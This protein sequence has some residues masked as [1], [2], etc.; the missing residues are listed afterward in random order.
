M[1]AE[2]MARLYAI[3]GR[4][5]ASS[6]P[7]DLSNYQYDG[8]ADRALPQAVVM[9]ADTAQVA[10]VVRACNQFGVAFVAR[11]AGTGLSG[12]ALAE[13]GGVVISTARLCRILEIDALNRLAV[14]E[15]GV[16]NAQVSESVRHLGLYFVPDPSSQSVCTIGGNV[17]EN[18]GG[19]H[20]LA[21]GVTAHHVLGCEVVMPNGEI[22]WLGGKTVDTPGYDLLGVFVG[23]EG[24]LGITT[25]VVVKLV[26]LPEE[27]CTLVAAFPTI[28]QASQSVSDIIAAGIIP[29]ALEMMDQLS[30]QAV[31]AFV[32]AGFPTDAGAVVIVELEGL[33]EAVAE[34]AAAVQSICSHNDAR[35]IRRAKN[36]AERHLIWLGRK[37]TFGAMGQLGANYYV[38]DGVIPRTHLPAVVAEVEAIAQRYGL[39]IANVFHAGDG[40]LHPLIVFDDRVAGEYD[41]TVAAGA[42]ILRVCVRHG[43]SISGEHG[44]GIEKRDCMSLQYSPVDL[45]LMAK[46]KSA[47]N[48]R[49]LCNPKK[50]FPTSRR[51]GESAR[52]QA[53]GALAPDVAQAAG[54]AF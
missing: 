35:E 6:S 20:S 4:D 51:C 12:G 38:Q 44:I 37:S 23:S 53:S 9:P 19:L 52:T 40:N 41:K 26:P 13:G 31:E 48:P 18:S 29:G 54:P 34:Q 47:F 43:G 15:P 25:K 2:L 28:A 1:F 14:V 42:D 24:T 45:A 7:G 22:V 32:H 21:Y 39:K 3:V 17:A 30:T 33:H 8:S 36:E 27:R 50:I 10:E 5:Y 11:G 16:V 46:L 49:G